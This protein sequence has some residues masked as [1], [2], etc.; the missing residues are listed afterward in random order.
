MLAPSL[1]LVSSGG[2]VIERVLELTAIPQEV[3]RAEL[4]KRD[5]SEDDE[6]ALVRRARQLGALEVSIKEMKAQLAATPPIII[7]ADLVCLKGVMH[8]QKRTERKVEVEG[9][10]GR[11]LTHYDYHTEYLLARMVRQDMIEAIYRARG[12]YWPG[13]RKRMSLAVVAF[14]EVLQQGWR[15][16]SIYADNGGRTT[17]DQDALHNLGLLSTDVLYVD[18]EKAPFR[19]DPNNMQNNGYPYVRPRKRHPRPLD[20]TWRLAFHQEISPKVENSTTY[21]EIGGSAQKT[22]GKT[23]SAHRDQG[24]LF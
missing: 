6:E 14:S 5:I 16:F 2:V 10:R 8:S 12:N 7:A 3:E 4:E 9:P 21:Q 22:S 13:E 1:E 23:S 20:L 24:S 18:T 19:I 11:T 15:N 17:N